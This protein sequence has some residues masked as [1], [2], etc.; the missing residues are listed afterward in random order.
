MP[1]DLTTSLRP[2]RAMANIR[3]DMTGDW[4][5][6]PWGWPEYTF[7]LPDQLGWFKRR[8]RASGIRRV[9]NIEVPKENFGIRPAII[10][11]PLDRLLYQSLV[12]AT[13]LDLI[14][15]LADWTYGW[16]LSR[17]KT[18]AG[19]YASQVREW[20]RYRAYLKRAS[21]MFDYGL[22]TDI[23]SCFACIPVDA[24]CKN[25]ETRAGSNQVTNR[26]TDM[27][28]AFNCVP[29]RS[30]LPQRSKASAALANMY[31]DQMDNVFT[32]YNATAA[33]STIVE[34]VGGTLAV[35]WMDDFWAFGSDD[36]PLRSFQIDLQYLARTA[37]LEL[38]LGKTRL[39][40]DDDLWSSVA[41]IE[42][43][44]VDAALDLD[45]SDVEPLEHLIDQL[46]ESPE[47]A[48]RT[49]I[50]FAMTR[51]RR[52]K[53]TSRLDDLLEVV[54]RMPHGADHIARVL[55]DFDIWRH[56]QEWFL[57]YANSIWGEVGWSVAQIGTMF[58]TMIR[59]SKAIG[60]KFTQLLI[61]RPSFPLFTL[62]AQRLSG[63]APRRTRDLLHDMLDEVEHPQ[64]RRVMGLV[65]TAVHEDRRFIRQILN[66][67][68]ENQLTLAMLEE[69]SF[70]PLPPE[71][72]FGPK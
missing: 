47:K 2:I 12:D 69:R 37:G 19:V 67:C 59:P 68:E 46:V 3:R 50:R 14:G 22:K 36:G 38:N 60:D 7:L 45:P 57:N 24:L 32:E 43:S 27:L 61:E 42:H 5:R 23:V 31:L 55:Q 8:A 72:D 17:A 66:E 28:L 1:D 63:W 44:A 64:E 30:G 71:S 51:M 9:V 56:H 25:I 54:P 53:L 70:E 29:G 48:D 13:A 20:E 65:A 10:M 62:S 52:E 33:P 11:E 39:Y 15:K 18:R 58:P 16:R 35:R 6:D 41:K 4:Y 34:S 40:A 49:S 21:L 26:L